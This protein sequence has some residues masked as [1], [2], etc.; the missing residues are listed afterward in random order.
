MGSNPVRVI[1]ILGIFTFGGLPK[2]LKGTVLKTVRRSCRAWVQIPH[3]PLLIIA[4][5]SSL[6]A[7]RAHN[8]KA[9]GS[10]PPPAIWSIGA[11]VYLV[12]LSRRRSSVQI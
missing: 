12:S 8:P 6:V 11:V 5:W 1:T 2:W 3:P 10:N 9:G 7:R 4:G